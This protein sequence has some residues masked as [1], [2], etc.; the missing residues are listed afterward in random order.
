MLNLLTIPKIDHISLKLD[1]LLKLGKYFV[2]L[3]EN[4]S[5]CFWQRFRVSLIL[6]FTVSLAFNLHSEILHCNM[7]NK[8]FLLIKL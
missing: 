3:F 1:A 5:R 6:I 7:K 4:N 2:S 8:Q